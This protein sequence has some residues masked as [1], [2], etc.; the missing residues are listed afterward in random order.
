M[1]V[2]VT[3]PG[4]TCYLNAWI[5][6]NADGDFDDSGEKL[7]ADNL[8]VTDGLAYAAPSRSRPA[9]SSTARRSTRASG[10]P[11]SR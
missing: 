4:G 11:T 3:C 6:W 5:D 8:A 2:T 9:L 10:S 7:F 1:D